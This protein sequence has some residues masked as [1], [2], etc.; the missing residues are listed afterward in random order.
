M[1]KLRT[2]RRTADN[3]TFAIG[4]VSCFADSFVLAESFVLRITICGKNPAHHKSA[5]SYRKPYGDH[6]ATS[7]DRKMN[8]KPTLQK[9]KKGAT[10]PTSRHTVAPHLF[11]PIAQTKFII[12]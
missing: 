4:G 8:K 3:S 5:K 7:N 9:N 12:Q 11:F 1:T 10:P 6:C 2:D